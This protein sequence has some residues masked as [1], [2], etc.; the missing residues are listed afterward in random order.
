MLLKVIA[1]E[2]F[3]REACHCA[4]HSPHVIDLEFTP[5]DAHNNPD[6]LRN[7]L[8]ERINDADNSNRSYN[9]IVLCMGICGNATID[10]TSAESSIIIPRAHDCCT[11]FLGSKERFKKI[12]GE[13]PSTPFSS[14]GYAEHD[15][16]YLHDPYAFSDSMGQNRT[17]DD[18]VKEYGEE[19]AKYIQETL[20][21]E[22]QGNEVIFIEIPEFSDNSYAEE[23]RIQTE[24]AG[25]QFTKTIGSMELIRK[26]L[27]GEWN[28]QDILTVPKGKV[29]AGVYDMDEIV[30]AN[31]C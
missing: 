27:H 19:N 17:Y 3:T 20:H 5:K 1:C 29:I 2:V 15:G 25:K 28:E 14:V 7:L 11:I 22:I 12:F 30:K 18:Y 13:K 9:A 16:N 10:L 31:E 24:A 23:C 6:T 26:L 8:Q 4:A 21:R